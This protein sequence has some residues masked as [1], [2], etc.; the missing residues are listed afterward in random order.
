MVKPDQLKLASAALFENNRNSLP[1]GTPCEL[2]IL[3]IIL[4]VYK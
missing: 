1:K 3:L 4:F 2:Y